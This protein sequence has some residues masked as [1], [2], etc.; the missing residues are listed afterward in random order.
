MSIAEIIRVV[1]GVAFV[2]FVPGL[3]WSY[4]FFARKSIDW[5]ERIALSLG[6]S[7]ALV[8]I[9]VFWLNRL[10]GMKITL[11]NVSITVCGLILVPIAYGLVRRSTWGSNALAK[12]KS[13]FR[14]I[15][16]KENQH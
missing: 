9:T 1:F 13:A 10:F 14:N 11:P 4:V 16:T 7:I 2:L 12:L 5:I 15:R 8:P 3:A 6:L